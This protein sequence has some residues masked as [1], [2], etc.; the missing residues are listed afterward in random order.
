MNELF[1]QPYTFSP[2]TSIILDKTQ[3]NQALFYC[4][5]FFVFLHHTNLYTNTTTTN[6]AI[7]YL[8]IHSAL[9]LLTFSL[10]VLSDSLRPHGLQHTRP[11]CP[12]P[13]PG[14]CPSSCSLHQWCQPAISSSDG[15]LSFCPGSFPTSGTLPKSCLFAS[16]DQ[17]YWSFSFSISLFSEY[18]G[19]ISLKTDWF[20]LP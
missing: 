7:K 15:L 17:K 14:V 8:G 1:V 6:T 20:D 3:K 4:P 11:P 2:Q 13:S 10:P 12:S 5:N 19:L 9:L 16:D 18:T